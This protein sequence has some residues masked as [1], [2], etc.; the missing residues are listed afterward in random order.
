[1]NDVEVQRKEL[2]YCFLTIL[3]HL[4]RLFYYSLVALTYNRWRQF[5]VLWHS[6]F[7]LSLLLC[8]YFV[9]FHSFHCHHAFHGWTLHELASSLLPYMMETCWAHW[10]A[11]WFFMACCICH[12]TEIR[13]LAFCSN[14]ST[15]MFMHQL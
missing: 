12:W 9:T 15:H 4:L 14:C 5:Y 11:H 10:I 2:F 1:M 7:P 13:E 6:S 8:W 3:I